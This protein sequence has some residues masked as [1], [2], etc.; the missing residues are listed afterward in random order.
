MTVLRWLL[1]L[2]PIAVLLTVVLALRW[3]SQPALQAQSDQKLLALI[4]QV[5]PLPYDNQPHIAPLRREDRFFFGLPQD[6]QVY[7]LR[8]D[9]EPVG[10][11][12]FPVRSPGYNAPIELAIGIE[13]GERVRAVRVLGHNETPGVGDL[14]SDPDWLEQFRGRSLQFPADAQWALRQDGGVFDQISGASVSSRAV[15][16]AVR[17]S[18][19]FYSA[20]QERLYQE[21]P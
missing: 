17:D 5:L 7:R 1:A 20:Q 12:L 6:F 21:A 3:L 13:A 16:Y 11:V 9:D 14:I 4:E 15:I 2:L 8:R 18:L 19:R 10:L